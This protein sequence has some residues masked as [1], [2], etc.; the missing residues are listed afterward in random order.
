MLLAKAVIGTIGLLLFFTIF[1]I[2]IG[3]FLI[4]ANLVYLVKPEN[5]YYDGLMIL[6]W[7][8]FF[9]SHN[10]ILNLKNF[11][12]PYKKL[13]LTLFIFAVIGFIKSRYFADG[14][15]YFTNEFIFPFSLVLII[16]NS[17]ISDAAAKKVY[18]SLVS[19]SFIVAVIGILLALA[20]PQERIGSTWV[21]AMTINAFYL[22]CFYIA[23]G[24]YFD[25]KK[26]FLRVLYII[27]AFVIFL[28][29]LFTYTRMA[30]LGVIFGLGL[31]SLK[32]KILRKYFIGFVFLGILMIPQT[33][34]S[35]FSLGMF[36]DVSMIIRYI[37]WVKSIHLIVAHP[38]TGIGFQT[39]KYINVMPEQLQ[40]LYA[41]H[42]HN[43]YLRLALEVGVVGMISYV[44]IIYNV[45]KK[46]LKAFGNNM[47][48]FFVFVA[49]LSTM[50]TC[51]TD[52][53]IIQTPISFLFWTIIG[54]M[55]NKLRNNN[56]KY[57]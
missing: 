14:I 24:L 42:S 4:V 43:V 31:A 15:K 26:K 8:I 54:L 52:V 32:I 29:L 38:L 1:K 56:K 25:S 21:T 51:L 48:D 44:L 41:E 12:F 57:I 30:L 22:I 37:V 47:M 55:F 5:F 53:F 33:L 49:I 3:N 13:Y 46:Y 35:R 6:A 18:I 17:K 50:F 28:G 2:N 34:M 45:L 10:D 27:M 23:I 20:H 11:E 9:I 19:V 7:G 39:F 36:K 40:F 16:Y